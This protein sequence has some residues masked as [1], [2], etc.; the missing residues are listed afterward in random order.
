MFKTLLA[1]IPPRRSILT[2]LAKPFSKRIGTKLKKSGCKLGYENKLKTLTLQEAMLRGYRF[3]FR[4][5]LCYHGA[6][7]K[8]IFV[9]IV[10]KKIKI[11]LN[12]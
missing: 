12:Y 7:T 10:V 5:I 4:S 9:V 2:I 1:E 8:I 3:F 11:L 6:Q